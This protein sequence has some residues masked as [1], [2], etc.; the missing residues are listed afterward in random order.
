VEVIAKSRI[1][2][3]D[4][5]GGTSIHSVFPELRHNN[6]LNRRPSCRKF[7][8]LLFVG[9]LSGSLIEVSGLVSLP[10]VKELVIEDDAVDDE[11]DYAREG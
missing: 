5:A 1:V 8:T 3:C 9:G 10:A 4:V 2:D 6:L 7:S 11:N